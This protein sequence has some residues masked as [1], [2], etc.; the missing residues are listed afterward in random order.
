MKNNFK[1]ILLFGLLILL[2]YNL[3]AENDNI[4]QAQRYLKLAN[5]YLQANNTESAMLNYNK[6]KE[7]IVKNYNKNLKYWDAA[8]DETLGNIYLK[9][10]NLP[11]AKLSYQTALN[12]YKKILDEKGNSPEAIKMILESIDDNSFNMNLIERASAKIISLDNSKKI[13]QNLILPNSVESFSCNNC[14]LNE[15]PQAFFNSSNLKR[16]VLS[17][18]KIKQFNISKMQKLEYLDLSKN[19]IKTINGNFYDLPNL[20]YLNL[21]DNALKEIPL[22]INELKNLKI[23]NLKGNKIPFSFIKTLI[24]N[25]PNTLIINDN[26]QLIEESTESGEI[27]E[28]EENNN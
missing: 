9:L 4:E 24:Q 20:Q 13:T 2:T 12:K 27:I 1:I 11:L 3:F 15:V 5:T 7:I 6:A 10:G 22:S 19:K 16:V 18:N 23:L 25:M 21:S 28:G 26:Y 8:A 17:N 14:K